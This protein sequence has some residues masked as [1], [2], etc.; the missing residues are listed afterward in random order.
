MRPPLVLVHGFGAC[1]HFWRRWE[2][3]LAAFGPV[4]NVELAGFGNTP[5]PDDGDSSP[6]GHARRLAGFLVE[7][8]GPPPILVGHSFGGAVVLLAALL[9]KDAG[10]PLPSALVVVSGAVFPQRIPPI[11]SA[12]RIPGLRSLFR[13]GPPPRWLLRAGIRT[14]VH[15]PATVTDDQVEGYLAPLRTPARR[16]EI[17]EAARRLDPTQ[18]A[19]W[20]LR[21]PE[22]SSPSLLLWGEEDRVVPPAV[23]ERLHGTLPHSTLVTLP[24]VGHLPPEEAP[25]QALE[26]VRSFL[27]GLPP[28]HG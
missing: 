16:R 7:L 6:L 15:D 8:E 21:Y 5:F 13:L 1:A 23:G 4:Y 14:I 11:I 3:S 27:D 20:T 18:G 2:G 26:V 19:E 10:R 12:A 28:R 25:D 9:E 22:I 24:G 17:L